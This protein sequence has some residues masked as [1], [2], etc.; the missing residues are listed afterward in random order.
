MNDLLQA[1][2]ARLT[3]DQ[4]PALGEIEEVQQQV[5]QLLETAM[6]GPSIGMTDQMNTVRVD[7]SA[8]VSSDPVDR[9]HQVLDLMAFILA[10]D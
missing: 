7:V 10:H 9:H 3:S 5:A 1:L 4:I 2:Q 8:Q 6:V